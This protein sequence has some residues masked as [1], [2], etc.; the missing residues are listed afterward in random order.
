[1]RNDEL[2]ATCFSFIIPHS[3]FIISVVADGSDAASGV[4]SSTP[5]RKNR[6]AGVVRWHDARRF[7][8]LRGQGYFST[9]PRTEEPSVFMAFLIHAESYPTSELPPPDESM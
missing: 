1:M 5:R 2:K 9:T 8:V 7:K 6:A 3:S 4:S